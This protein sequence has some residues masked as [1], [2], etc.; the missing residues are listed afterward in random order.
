MIKIKIQYQRIIARVFDPLIEH[1]HYFLTLYSLV[2]DNRTE[3]VSSLRL[4]TNY[5]ILESLEYY[6]KLH[7]TLNPCL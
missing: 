5:P 4:L 7:V 6:K 1:P 3:F 2:I